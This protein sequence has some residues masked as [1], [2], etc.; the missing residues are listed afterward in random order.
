VLS[1][2]RLALLS[3]RPPGGRVQMESGA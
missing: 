3:Q 1:R 2:A